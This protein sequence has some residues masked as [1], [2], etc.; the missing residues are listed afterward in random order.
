MN[1]AVYQSTV[2][3][4]CVGVCFASAAVGALLTSPNVPEWYE[5]LNKPSWTPPSWVFGPIWSFLYLL[6]GISA[7][8]VWRKVGFR[9]AVVPLVLF[10]VQ[11]ILNMLWS[12]LFFGL[13]SPGVALI[14]IVFLWCAILAT[15]IAFYRRSVAAGWLMLPYLAWVSFALAL[16]LAIW[17][18]NR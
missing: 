14:E 2:L 6:M 8:Q 3:V 15:T 16:N 5:N 4:M 12:G 11:L 9:L 18:L 17:S 13:R 10:G 1:S 7:W